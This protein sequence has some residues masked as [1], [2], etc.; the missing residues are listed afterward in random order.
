M[1]IK[2]ERITVEQTKTN[3][4]NELNDIAEKII[5]FFNKIHK[6]LNSNISDQDLMDIGGFLTHMN[7]YLGNEEKLEVEIN[8]TVNKI[9]N[10]ISR[11]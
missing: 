7:E 2:Q 9:N 1:S 5:F 11:H 6:Q 10:A 3:A 4:I 8:K